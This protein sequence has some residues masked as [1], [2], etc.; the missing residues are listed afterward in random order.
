[1]ILKMF[2]DDYLIA[3]VEG[4]IAELNVRLARPTAPPLDL[5]DEMRPPGGSDRKTSGDYS[6]TPDSKSSRTN[7]TKPPFNIVF[8]RFR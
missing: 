6:E 8:H 4:H 2:V 1:M 3:L 5:E 7:D